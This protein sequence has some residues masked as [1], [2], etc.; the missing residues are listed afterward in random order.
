MYTAFH[1]RLSAYTRTDLR[2]HAVYTYSPSLA[3]GSNIILCFVALLFTLDHSC[4]YRF[5][6]QLGEGSRTRKKRGIDEKKKN[7]EEQEGGIF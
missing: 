3:K 1:T 6:P 4:Q 7:R 5:C 2:I